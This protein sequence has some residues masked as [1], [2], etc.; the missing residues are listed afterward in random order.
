[1]L[2]LR[3]QPGYLVLL[4]SSGAPTKDRDKAKHSAHVKGDVT[5]KRKKKR[6]KEKKKTPLL[7]ACS[8]T[9][10]A[11]ALQVDNINFG[12]V[13]RVLPV[14]DA[15]LAVKSGALIADPD[16]LA[17]GIGLANLVIADAQIITRDPDG[18][19]AFA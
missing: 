7:Y 11:L 1:M 3:R 16:V 12:E 17:I 4:P 13:G 15:G 5:C 8:Y 18:W 6:E 9:I 19:A 2:L 10:F 14:H